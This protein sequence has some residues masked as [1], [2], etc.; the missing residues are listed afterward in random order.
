MSLNNL[1]I[2]N[3]EILY[4]GNMYLLNL[5][6]VNFSD[7][8]VIGN[9]KAGA[10]HIGDVNTSTPIY[11]GAP[12]GSTG[13]PVYID[14]ILWTPGVTGSIGPVGPTGQL[15]PVGPIGPTG[16]TGPIGPTG[17]KGAT[18]VTGPY[19]PQSTANMY[20]AETG[21]TGTTTFTAG[22]WQKLNGFY[23][24]NNLNNFTLPSANLLTY[25]GPGENAMIVCNLA[26]HGD[27]GPITFNANISKNGATGPQPLSGIGQK[28][29]IPTDNYALSMNACIPLATNDTISVQ[30]FSDVD[31][32]LILEFATLSVIT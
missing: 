21:G 15:G 12:Y 16:V 11:I 1:N 22:Q 14:G 18:G 24:S 9:A 7:P 5:D 27:T 10:I 20:W 17:L 29:I 8:L 30:A 26:L 3:D 32:S 28:F 31:A 19:G 2:P 25:T 4:A 6:A 23:S 13:S